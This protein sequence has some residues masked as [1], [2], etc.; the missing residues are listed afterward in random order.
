MK[1]HLFF[2]ALSALA[3]VACSE[4]N[5]ETSDPQVYSVSITAGENGTAEASPAKAEKGETVTLTA[6]PAE[7]YVLAGWAVTSGNVSLSDP[8]GN[9]VT[10]TMPGAD[11]TITASFR[12]A[13]AAT[14]SIT[15]MAAEGGEVNYGSATP[16]F[17]E[18]GVLVSISDPVERPKEVAE[19]HYVTMTATAKDGWRFTDWKVEKGDINATLNKVDNKAAFLM[20]AEE[21][22]IVAEFEEAIYD[23]TIAEGIEHGKVTVKGN[24]TSVPEGQIVTLTAVPDDGYKFVRWDIEGYELN[25]ES[26]VNSQ[27]VFKMPG[28]DVVISAKFD[29][30]IEDVLAEIQDPVFRAYAE[31]RMDHEQTIVDKEYWYEN[32]NAWSGSGESRVPLAH[33]TITE[34]PTTYPRWDTDGDGKLSEEEAGRIEAIDLSADVLAALPGFDWDRTPVKSVGCNGYLYGLKVLQISKQGLTTLD[35]REFPVLET[36]VCDYNKIETVDL[37]KCRELKKLFIEHNELTNLDISRNKVYS[38]SCWDNHIEKFYMKHLSSKDGMFFFRC[39]SQ[40]RPDDLEPRGEL[41]FI[42]ERNEGE[43]YNAYCDRRSAE[44]KEKDLYMGILVYYGSSQVAHWNAIYDAGNEY[45]YNVG[46]GFSS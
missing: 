33:T 46:I 29:L 27:V 39:G 38:I 6:T 10:F 32:L 44:L 1:K 40:R 18:N 4:D 26:L 11:V 35:A 16:T 43:G 8:A 19:G 22:F 20:P 21:V 5:T 7:G 23:L 13:D 30:P 3:F 28:N 34:T 42:I 36:L 15:V 41:P 31:Y 12:E 24:L 2:L 45:F 14:Y 9:P 17:D 25:A 37:T